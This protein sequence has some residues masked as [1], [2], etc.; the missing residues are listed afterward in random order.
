MK[1]NLL[2]KKILLLITVFTGL[3]LSIPFVVFSNQENFSQSPSSRFTEHP[4][5][6]IYQ[7]QVST[8]LPIYIK[9]PTIGVD[10]SIE[11]V[12]L[13]PDGAMDVPSNP[14][15]VA[16]YN[17]GPRP[18]EKGS[19][20]IAGHYGWKNN[21]PAVFDNLYEIKTGDKIY[22]E[23]ETGSNIIFVVREILIY[24]RNQD[25]SDVFESTDGK[26]HL[27][28]IT[29]TGNWDSKENTRTERLIIFA[30]KE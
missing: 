18:G 4:I 21:L 24:D 26:A 8:T 12:G 30:D 14:A 19:A 16:W 28:L 17:L 6:F 11:Y 20:V 23:D 2:S 5:T 22:I 29:C 1:S 3:I 15:N 27:N 7:Q 25:A 9:I 10:A 13:T